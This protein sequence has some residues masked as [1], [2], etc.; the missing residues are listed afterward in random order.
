M[1]YLIKF[2]TDFCE[3]CEQTTSLIVCQNCQQSACKNCLAKYCKETTTG[4]LCN[5]CK[6]KF[7][8]LHSY[9]I[10]GEYSPI[11]IRNQVNKY[12]NKIFQHIHCEDMFTKPKLNI[13]PN[14]KVYLEFCETRIPLHI[15]FLSKEVDNI[16]DSPVIYTRGFRNYCA[17][18]GHEDVKTAPFENHNYYI[19]VFNYIRQRGRNIDQIDNMILCFRTMEY[20]QTE[21][22]KQIVKNTYDLMKQLILSPYSNFKTLD[23]LRR[24]LIINSGSYEELN[25]FYKEIDVDSLPKRMDKNKLIISSLFKNI[26][27]PSHSKGKNHK[28]YS[29]LRCYYNDYN[30]A[31]SELY[32]SVYDFMIDDQIAITLMHQVN[33][34]KILYNFTLAYYNKYTENPDEIH[35]EYQEMITLY[36]PLI[37]TFIH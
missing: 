4:C 34:Y 18:L 13:V 33:K 24:V 19:N 15:N 26:E 2:T 23:D 6:N 3:F 5:K 9:V 22:Q 37:D 27:L 16:I 35:K 10:L 12:R 31:C 32:S 25:E 7:N 20:G 28:L 11:F 29:L 17:K 21:E 1:D 14:M 30:R 8:K 36:E